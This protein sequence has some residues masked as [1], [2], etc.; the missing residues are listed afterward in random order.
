MKAR[1]FTLVELLVVIA[2]ICVLASLLFPAFNRTRR[3][4]L[5]RRCR[6]EIGAIATAIRE[7]ESTYGRY[8]VSRSVQNTVATLAEDYTYGSTFVRDDGKRLVIGG[9]GEFLNNNNEVMAILLDLETYGNGE[10]TPNK[11]HIANPHHISFLNP[12]LATAT[13]SPG[14]G[15]DGAYRDPW[16]VTYMISLDLNNDGFVRDY[17]YRSPFVSMDTNNPEGG[18]NGLLKRKDALNHPCFEVN[19]PVIVWSP[20]PD[21]MINPE[22]KA[23]EGVNRDNVLSWK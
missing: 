17:F 14:L 10:T 13:N 3:S 7:Y 9:P 12:H 8:P 16:G 21:E 23:N 2:I 19:A 4:V 5:I 6:D 1:A 18:L 11:G 22:E 20:G 15:P